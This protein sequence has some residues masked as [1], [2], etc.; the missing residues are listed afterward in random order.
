[1]GDFGVSRVL[2]STFDLAKTNIGT[3]YYLSPEIVNAKPY[4]Q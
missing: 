1:L 2:N 3:P 4:N